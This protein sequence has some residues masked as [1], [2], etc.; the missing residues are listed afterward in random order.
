LPLFP[1]ASHLPLFAFPERLREATVRLVAGGVSITLLGAFLLNF[2][3]ALP[4]L[5][6][7]FGLRVAAGPRFSPLARLAA[8]LTGALHLPERTIAGAPKQFAAAIGATTLTVASLLW[9]S[10]LQTAGWAVAGLVA[11]LAGLEAALA[12]CLGCRIYDA[13]FGCAECQPSRIWKGAPRAP[14]T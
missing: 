14:S 11:T 12:F 4:A 9:L 5:A 10:G 6:I 8:V 3:W 1:N 7:G 2:G 13:L